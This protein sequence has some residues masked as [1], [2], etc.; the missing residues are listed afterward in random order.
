MRNMLV[1]YCNEILQCNLVEFVS[2]SFVIKNE[3]KS[4]QKEIIVRTLLN[5][6]SNP[7]G[8]QYTL[9]CKYWIKNYKPW[10]NEISNVWGNKDV[11]DEMF[12]E[13][14][15]SLLQTELG[16]QLLPDYRGHFSNTDIY[17]SN[18]NVNDDFED[19]INA[20]GN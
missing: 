3:I 12:C 13:K 14:W 2:K 7:K 11:C 6:Y 4:R 17:F 10:N 5:R 15:N 1:G 16:H 9:L 20:S 18:D 8:V 19:V